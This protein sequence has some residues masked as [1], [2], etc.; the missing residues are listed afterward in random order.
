MVVRCPPASR[1]RDLVGNEIAG[2]FRTS[3]AVSESTWTARTPDVLDVDETKALLSELKD[4][5]W[6]MVFV[7]ATTGL[8]VSEIL[9]MKWQDVVFGAEKFISAARSSMV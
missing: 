1:P 8:R 9:G 2:R 3:R 6:T 7:A 4:P 5:F